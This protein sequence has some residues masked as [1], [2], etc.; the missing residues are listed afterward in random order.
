MYVEISDFA[1]IQRQ[2]AT[3]VSTILMIISRSSMI[4]YP[5]MCPSFMKGHYCND[6]TSHQ[7][8]LCKINPYETPY[9]VNRGSNACTTTVSL[10]V[11][12]NQQTPFAPT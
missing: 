7:D 9:A 6:L 12:L 5:L 3:I 4:L 1:E 11:D 2:S 10:T 8:R